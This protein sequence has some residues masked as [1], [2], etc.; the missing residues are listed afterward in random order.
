[1]LCYDGAMPKPVSL[2]QDR[3]EIS[4]KITR[5]LEAP[6][7]VPL[8]LYGECGSGK[9]A[10][11]AST[12]YH[13]ARAGARKRTVVVARFLGTTPASSTIRHTLRSICQQVRADMPSSE[14]L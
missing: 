14:E 3:P 13:H 4:S 12:G 8:V 5:Y 11:M 2:V 9:T 10:V 6:S 7:R 1:M